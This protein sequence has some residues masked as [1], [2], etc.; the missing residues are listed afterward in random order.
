MTTLSANVDYAPPVIMDVS[1]LT[2][3]CIGGD[4]ILLQIANLGLVDVDSVKGS[5]GDYIID[6]VQV[7]GSHFS[8]ISPP[9]KAPGLTQKVYIQVKNSNS[10]NLPDF[11]TPVA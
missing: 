6:A 5:V 10:F 3:P 7:N 9:S 4:A 2:L 8:F 1:P 11:Q